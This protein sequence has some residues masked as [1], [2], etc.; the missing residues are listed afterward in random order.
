VL[1][2]LRQL[3]WLYCIGSVLL[4]LSWL[5][6]KQFEY[7][8][9]SRREN[10]DRLQIMMTGNHTIAQV[11]YSHI[12]LLDSQ[13]EKNQEAIAMASLFYMEFTLNVLQSAVAW[14]NDDL[15]SR[16]A[17]AEFRE[18]RLQTAKAAFRDKDFQQVIKTAAQLRALELQSAGILVPR[19]YKRYGEL[20]AD[21]R[22]W[23]LRLRV[24]YILGALLI[25]TAL[26]RSKLGTQDR[27]P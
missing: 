3:P 4:F 8:A 10:L 1:A 24:S 27:A 15:A 14:D 6:E 12:R 11:W 7:D 23:N 21:E 22:R 18:Q 13:A 16:Q 26:V 17:F 5:S 20:E 25:A 2:K 9:K 19:N